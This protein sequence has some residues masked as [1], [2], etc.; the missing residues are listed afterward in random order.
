MENTNN[1]YYAKEKMTGSEDRGE[2]SLPIVIK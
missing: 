1:C 2:N